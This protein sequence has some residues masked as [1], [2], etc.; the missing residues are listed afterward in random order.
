MKILQDLRKFICRYEIF[1]KNL[2]I[3]GS[4]IECGVLYGGGYSFKVRGRKSSSC[5]E[6]LWLDFD[7]Y[8]PTLIALKQLFPRIP[9]GGVI[10]FDELNHEVCPG[11]TISVMEEIGLTNLKIERFPFGGT[12]SYA[13]KA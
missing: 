9:Q 4:I 11:E 3:H 13:V 8:E 10:A 5:G 12:I 1:K 6:S 2:H 7:I